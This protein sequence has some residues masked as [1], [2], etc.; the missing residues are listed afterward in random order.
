LADSVT[1]LA[2]IKK[3]EPSTYLVGSRNV[4]EERLAQIEIYKMT[5]GGYPWLAES[6]RGWPWQIWLQYREG[7]IVL[8]L[9]SAS[10]SSP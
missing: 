9:W 2:S 4:M 8:A 6:T 1:Q 7:C 5:F 3:R 10:I